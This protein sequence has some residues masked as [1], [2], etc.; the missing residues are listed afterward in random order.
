MN[1]TWGGGYIY[2]HPPGDLSEAFCFHRPHGAQCGHRPH[3]ARVFN[4]KV[5]RFSLMD[6]HQWISMDIQFFEI[7]FFEIQ[8]HAKTNEKQWKTMKHH[9]HNKTLMNKP[10]KTIGPGIPWKQFLQE[11]RLNPYEVWYLTL[12]SPAPWGPSVQPEGPLIFIDGYT[13]IFID[14]YPSMDIQFFEIQL[15]EIQFFEKYHENNENTKKTQCKSLP[16]YTRWYNQLFF[17]VRPL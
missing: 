9:K 10:W 3:G 17:W 13:L 6:I 11:S 5:H 12:W 15:F 2:T 1:I 14:G 7:Q 8:F 16:S 4:Q